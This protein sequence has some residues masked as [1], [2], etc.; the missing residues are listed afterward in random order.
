MLFLLI[1]LKS[2]GDDFE[3]YLLKQDIYIYKYSQFE[4]F[5]YLIKILKILFFSE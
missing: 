4:N 5:H 1:E 2:I 3:K